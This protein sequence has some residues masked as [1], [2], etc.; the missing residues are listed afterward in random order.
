MNAILNLRFLEPNVH[1]E[2]LQIQRYIF[3]IKQIK[4]KKKKIIPYSIYSVLNILGNNS[5]FRR[6]NKPENYD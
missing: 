2:A 6:Y 4:A 5:Y 3:E 1:K